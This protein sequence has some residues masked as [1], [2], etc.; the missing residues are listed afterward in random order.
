MG[1]AQT[2]SCNPIQHNVLTCIRGRACR[3]AF[4]IK[5]RRG[6]GW[7][8]WPLFYLLPSTLCSLPSVLS[9]RLVALSPLPS[10]L[11]PLLYALCS[12]VVADGGR[13]RSVWVR[14]V[15]FRC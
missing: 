7:R 4:F 12:L 6:H 5:A 3:F 1:D 10:T 15:S 11:Y 9:S 2:F 13:A 8:R 14:S